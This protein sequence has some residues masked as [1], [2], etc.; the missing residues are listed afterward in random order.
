MK[1]LWSLVL[2]VLVMPGAL[3]AAPDATRSGLLADLPSFKSFSAAR[4]SSYDPSGGNAD[5]RHDWPIQP[6]ETRE[7][8]KLSGA[9]AIT[10]LWFTVASKDKQHLKNLVLR[11][12][13]DGEENPSVEAPIGDFFG[14]GNNTYYQYDSLP[15]Q[16]GTD[17]GLNCF[18]RMPFSD[19]ARVTITNDGPIATT[20]FY[21]Y[22]DY[23]KYK[24]LPKAVGRFHAQY[25]Q[26][27]PCVPRQNY[28]LVDAVGRGHYVGC[29]LSIHNREGAWW[30]EGDDMMY[31]DGAEKPQLQGTGAEDYFCGAWAYGDTFSN[32]YFGC[33][34]KDGGHT[35]N[36][37]WN[38]YRYHLED[39]IPFEKSIKVTIEHGHANN[40][41]DDYSSV[42]YWYQ[43]EPHVPFPAMPPASDRMFTEAT[44]YTEDWTWEA[45]RLAPVFKSDQVVKQPMAEYG[46]FWSHGHQLLFNATEPTVFRAELPAKPGEKVRYK[47]KVWYTAGPEYG[48]AELWYNGTKACEW[49]GYN[50]DGVVR[51][52]VMSPEP[53][54]VTGSANV[55]EI[56]VVGKNQASSG[57]LV[58]W[59]CTSVP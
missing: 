1:K 36:A 43:S 9:G 22:V 21:Y 20:S 59:D 14:L 25:R 34:Q 38:V 49:D 26:E 12:Y 28:V 54:E 56:R 24:R 18:W 50:A 6:G 45:E 53:V 42:G 17:K 44:I 13:W 31:I 23:Q 55:F 57:Y 8:A 51:K 46:N 4:E 5:G 47:I 3:W 7:I 41:G 39:P 19:G 16:I 48:Q 37:L 32:L 33:P 58:G 2:F 40:R 11:M 15:I 30:G 27:Y 10:H 29:N 35:R 52:M